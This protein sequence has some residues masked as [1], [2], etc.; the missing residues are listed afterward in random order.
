[1]VPAC[2][3][4]FDKMTTWNVAERF[5]AEEALQFLRDA[6]ARLDAATLDAQVKLRLS[7][8]ADS[9]WAMLSPETLGKWSSFRTP[10]VT[11]G[12]N[13]LEWFLQ[14]RITR[15]PILAIRSLFGI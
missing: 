9:Y 1:M 4:L 3:A 15:T 5:T 2:A 8:S 11:Q 6:T 13:V 14:F 10:P 12:S 7:E